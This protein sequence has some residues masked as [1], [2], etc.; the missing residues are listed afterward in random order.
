MNVKSYPHDGKIG[1]YEWNLD[2]QEKFENLIKE[3]FK[4][5]CEIASK[6]PIYASLTPAIHD[7]EDVKVTPTTMLVSLPLGHYDMDGLD[8]YVCYEEL[9][10]NFINGHYFRKGVDT[11]EITFAKNLAVKLRELADRLDEAAD[12]DE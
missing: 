2:A 8:Y 7:S 4:E 1:F 12:G 6:E 10:A 11:P 9:V 3:C 5:A